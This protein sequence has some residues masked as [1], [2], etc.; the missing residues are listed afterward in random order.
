MLEAI[1]SACDPPPIAIQ[2]PLFLAIKE[3]YSAGQNLLYRWLFPFHRLLIPLEHLRKKEL[4]KAGIGFRLRHKSQELISVA[5][6]GFL[7]A[8]L[9]FLAPQELNTIGLECG[10]Q[11]SVLVQFLFDRVDHPVCFFERNT[12]IL[13]QL[14]NDQFQL[15]FLFFFLA[16]V[17]V[18]ARRRQCFYSA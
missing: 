8:G 15:L 9:Q 6:E 12:I 17:A 4:P 10:S 1:L 13:V 14:P 3:E 5:K 16:S 18:V 7:D 11:C 2:S